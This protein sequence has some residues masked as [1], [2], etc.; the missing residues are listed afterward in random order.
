MV[1]DYVR[2]GL[3]IFLAVVT[4]ISGIVLLANVTAKASCDAMTVQIGFPHRYSFLS[5]CMI[6]V[7]A[8]Q[9][10][11]LSNYYYKQP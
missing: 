11:P 7:K 4:A 8:G 1:N 9:W 5:G 6:E 10:I 3:T 2:V